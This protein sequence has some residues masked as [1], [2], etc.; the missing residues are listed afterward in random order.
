MS[1]YRH[2]SYELQDGV[3]LITLRR[4]EARNALNRRA[5][6]E[7]ADCWIRLREER[8]ALVGI[9]T[10]EGDRAFCSGADLRERTSPDEQDDPLIAR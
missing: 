8:H 10:G 1:D 4:P 7:L 6:A 3:A 9:I 5:Q 2:V